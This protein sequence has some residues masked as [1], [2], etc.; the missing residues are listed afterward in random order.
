MYAFGKHE[1]RQPKQVCKCKFRPTERDRRINP[2]IKR[3]GAPN[4]R[5]NAPNE[6]WILKK[7][8]RRDMSTYVHLHENKENQNDT[9]NQRTNSHSHAGS[10]RKVGGWA[11]IPTK[12][13][14]VLGCQV[15]RRQPSGR[16]KHTARSEEIMNP[17][18]LA[19]NIQE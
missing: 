6:T 1:N 19:K 15:Q 5:R 10:F 17:L 11:P 9:E 12:H 3:R 8:L 16:K 18:G 13:V 14:P 4:T 7:I 2:E